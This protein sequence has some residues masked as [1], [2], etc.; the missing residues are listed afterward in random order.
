MKI[1]LKHK[2]KNFDVDVKRCNLFQKTIGL[3][4]S[5]REKAKALL[6]DFK[7]P[8]REPITSWFV[9]FPFVAIWMDKENNI[10]ESRIIKPF[11]PIINSKKPFNRLVEVPIKKEYKEIIKIVVG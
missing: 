6:F 8:T 5:R 2:G 11:I 7:R 1:G 4:F 3:M 9:F 10:L